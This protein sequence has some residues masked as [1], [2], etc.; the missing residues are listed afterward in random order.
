MPTATFTPKA[1]IEL[2]NKLQVEL[3]EIGP[4]EFRKRYGVAVLLEIMEHVVPALDREVKQAATGTWRPAGKKI[5][6]PAGR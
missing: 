5:A 4:E 6:S 1:R 3:S 2:L